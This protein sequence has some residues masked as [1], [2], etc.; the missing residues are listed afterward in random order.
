M[1]IS[2]ESERTYLQKVFAAIGFS[3]E[4][5]ALLADTLV[6]ADLRGISSHGIQRLAWYVNMVK[7]HTIEP[8][9]E[10]K[11]LKE[12]ATSLLID[13]NK[14]MGQVACALAMHKLIEK[15]KK[16]VVSIAVIRNSNHFG[17][18]GYWAR[19]AVEEG[20]IGIANTNTRPLVVPPNATQ[21]FL[22]SNAFAFTFPAEPHPF[23]FD[24]ATSVVSSGKIQV[25]DKKNQEI[26]GE[27]AV[28]KERKIVKNARKAEDILA[29]AAFTP[30]QK[31]GGVLTL[32]GIGEDNSNYKGLGNSLVVEL[33]TGIL[34][35]GSI[36]ADTSVGKHDFSQFLMTIDPSFFGDLDTLRDNATS[37]FNRIR[38]LEHLPNTEIKIPGDREYKYYA[39]NSE[40]GV[41]VDD[42]TAED[43][44][45][46]GQELNVPVPETLS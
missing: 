43:L 8:K 37:M 44:K 9:N 22:G 45:R 4:N 17:T 10:V 28:D 31:G 2:A 13:A 14:N 40:N 38:N 27:W 5:S 42:K 19:M 1:R 11:V 7:E 12:T 24:G 46:I 26:P 34:A 36:S 16:S 18:A 32:G 21:A 30:H 29:T 20:L 39:E 3:N 23:V 25:L 33:L 35:Q 6:D 41:S 15:T